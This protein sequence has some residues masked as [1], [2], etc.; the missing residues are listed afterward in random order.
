MAPTE[1]PNSFNQTRPGMRRKSSA[2][3]MLATYK[4]STVPAGPQTSTGLTMQIPSGTLNSGMAGYP[5]STPTPTISAMSRDWESQSIASD[6]TIPSSSH[7]FAS[8][9]N[10]GPPLGASTSVESLRD[11]VTKRMI[12]LT[13]L[14]NVHEGYVIY[15]S[16]TLT[17]N[18]SFLGFVGKQSRSHWFNTI[19]MTRADME[20]EFS[21][22]NT[23]MKK[24]CVLSNIS[25]HL[26]SD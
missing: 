8:Q 15:S 18:D 9:G 4:P 7:T 2:Q 5:S 16:C 1:P 14:R 12:T 3:N 11:L 25:S 20:R 13:Y 17:R 19:L 10:G 26:T 21:N 24:R 23:A 6:F 22:S